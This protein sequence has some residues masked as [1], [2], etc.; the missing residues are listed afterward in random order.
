MHHWYTVEPLLR[1][2]PERP[3]P[4]KRPLDNTNVNVNVLTSTPD[5]RP[6]L[7]KGHLYGTKGWHHK[8]G[9]IIFLVIFPYLFLVSIIYILYMSKLHNHIFFQRI[10]EHRFG[11]LG[12]QSVTGH[13]AAVPGLASLLHAQRA[14]RAIL[15]E[16]FSWS[17]FWSSA[18]LQTGQW[19]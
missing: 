1:V 3:S 2:H 16:L 5:E 7:L 11:I 19:P 14:D 13:G 17:T 15:S 12:R 18:C 4:L 6:P 8:R 9:S 10:W